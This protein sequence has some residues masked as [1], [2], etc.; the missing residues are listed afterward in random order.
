ML[1]IDDPA[2]NMEFFKHILRLFIWGY[3][4]SHVFSIIFPY[5]PVALLKLC[6]WAWKIEHKLRLQEPYCMLLC[7][8]VVTVSANHNISIFILVFQL[9]CKFFMKIGEL[10]GY[11]SDTGNWCQ[12]SDCNL[13][14]TFIDISWEKKMQLLS[15]ADILHFH[16][17]RWENMQVICFTEVYW[18]K[19][20]LQGWH[21]LIIIN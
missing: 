3:N 13:F 10:S 4:R 2:E 5:S 14:L 1:S 18:L 6:S 8:R 9:L 17:N 16:W 15:F 21:K 20:Y 19:R 12:E 7:H 11:K